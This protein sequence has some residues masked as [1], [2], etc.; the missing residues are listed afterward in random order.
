M[1]GAVGQRDGHAA[2]PSPLGTRGDRAVAKCVQQAYGWEILL[3]NTGGLSRL[4]RLP[5]L[6][7]IGS[8][9]RRR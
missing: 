7:I 8:G 2:V 3:L 1:L 6:G 4:F 5:G 9:T